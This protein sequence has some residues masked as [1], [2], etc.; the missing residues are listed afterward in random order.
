MEGAAINEMVLICNIKMA[1][2]IN[3]V[4][5]YGTSVDRNQ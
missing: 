2:I 5:L 1:N 4:N 3:I